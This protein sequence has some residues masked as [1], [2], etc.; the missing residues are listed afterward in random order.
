MLFSHFVMASTSLPK[1]AHAVLFNPEEVFEMTKLLLQ[2]T[3][4]TMLWSLVAQ[5]TFDTIA[6]AR[7]RPSATM[8]GLL[9]HLSTRQAIALPCQWQ[10]CRVNQT[11]TGSALK[12]YFGQPA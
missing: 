12:S 6:H 7:Y 1:R 9:S 10:H 8:N 4:K 2:P 11:S 3:N 5:V